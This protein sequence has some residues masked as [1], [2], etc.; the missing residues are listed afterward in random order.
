MTQAAALP[1]LPTEALPTLP[2]TETDHVQF[3]RSPR[4]RW[5]KSLAGLVVVTLVWLIISMILSV[6][7]IVLDGVD[8]S[9]DLQTGTIVLGPWLFIMN[10]VSLALLIPV[11]MLGAW[12]LIGQR[13]GWLSSVA[14]RVR[15][16]WLGRV[17]LIVLPA[18]AVLHG[19]SFLLGEQQDLQ[20]RPYSVL[21]MVAILLTMPLQSAGEEYF[22]RGF[23]LRSVAAWIRPRTA[24]FLASTLVSSLFF[25]VIHFAADI[26]LNIFYFGFGVTAS[27]LAWRTGGLEAPI[28][29]HA[30]NN[31]FA[32]AT[33][34]FTDIREA[35]NREAGSGSPTVLV[36]LAGMVVI[37]VVLEFAARRCGIVTRSAPGRAQLEQALEQQRAWAAHAGLWSPA[38][39]PPRW[40][41]AP[42]R[43]SPPSED[44]RPEVPPPGDLGQN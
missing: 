15:W 34:P 40:G 43:G 3:F 12:V 5:W 17:A 4:F 31:L 19:L 2:V 20:W 29:L 25:T 32:A 27:W 38:P 37:A 21:L 33:L 35:F 26:W 22:L 28:A 18:W 11:T 39:M 7:G 42:D 16:G 41:L 36:P 8:T 9:L 13:P 23:V 6:T 1:P 24:A 44:P 14:G 30:I 10:N